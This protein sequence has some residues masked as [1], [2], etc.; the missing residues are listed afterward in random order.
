MIAIHIKAENDTNG[1]PR[2][3]FL[4]LE[5]HGVHDFVTEGYLG[6]SA[7]REAGYTE[8]PIVAIVNVQAKEYRRLRKHHDGPEGT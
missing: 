1:N 4:V 7:L 5:P 3:G 8:C 6:E 2:R